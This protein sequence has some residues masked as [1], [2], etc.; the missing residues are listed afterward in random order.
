M[1]YGTILLNLKYAGFSPHHY[2]IALKVIYIVFHFL[3]LFFMIIFASLA[4][5]QDQK[6]RLLQSAIFIGIMMALMLIKLRLYIHYAMIIFP[7]LPILFATISEFGE[8]FK[9]MK[10]FFKGLCIKFLMFLASIHICISIFYLKA[11][12]LNDEFLLRF[13]FFSVH[14]KRGEILH[15]YEQQTILEL[16]KIIPEDERSSFVCWG[17]ISNVSKW[18]LLTDMKPRDRLF[19]NNSNLAKIDP[20]LK[21]EWLDNVRKNYPLWILYDANSKDKDVEEL[22]AEKYSLKGV[23]VSGQMMKLYRLNE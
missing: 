9:T 13:V 22:L 15:S 1:L 12:F 11:L 18:I 5:K 23:Y 6:S 3:P 4:L 20:A 8:Y 17:G 10:F 21:E 16:Q 14:N 19:M 7:A 2:Q